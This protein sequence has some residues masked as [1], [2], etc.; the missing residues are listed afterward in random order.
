MNNDKISLHTFNGLQIQTGD[1]LC[2]TDGSPE[3]LA[4]E[5]WRLLGK[6]IPGAI[7]H[8]VIYVGPGGRCIEANGKGVMAFEMPG[9]TW[10]SIPL[11]SERGQLIDSL[12]GVAYPLKDKGFSRQVEEAIRIGVA[13]YCEFQARA[14]KPYNISFMNSDTE[15]SFY[16]SQ[17]AYRAYLGYGIDFNT[18]L[19]V[20]N[21]PG[22]EKIVFPQEIWESCLHVRVE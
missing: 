20:P 3:I 2:M 8:V 1:L 6:L 11:K 15:D 7:D 5:Y 12:Y 13:D 4:G 18:G 10:D 17:L 21:L 22:T 19:G 14:R 16:C 9:D